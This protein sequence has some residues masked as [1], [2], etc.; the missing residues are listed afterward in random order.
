[1]AYTDVVA[2]DAK[3][4]IELVRY[5]DSLFGDVQWTVKTRVSMD[6]LDPEPL[7]DNVTLTEPKILP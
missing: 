2:V 1:M 7:P 3:A 5:R 4:A 6:V